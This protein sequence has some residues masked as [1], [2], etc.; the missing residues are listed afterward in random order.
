M[1]HEKKEP[2]WRRRFQTILNTESYEM[3]VFEQVP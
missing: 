3:Q 1:T 2:P